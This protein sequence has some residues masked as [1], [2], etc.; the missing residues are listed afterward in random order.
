[1][2]ALLNVIESFDQQARGVRSIFNGSDGQRMRGNTRPTYLAQLAEAMKFVE[3]IW[4]GKRPIWQLQEALTTSD[5]PNLFGDIIDRM[6]LARYMELPA[7]YKQ[8]CKIGSVRDFRTVKRL[9]IDGNRGLLTQVEERSPYPQRK[10]TDG[11][12]TYAVTKY[13]G[14]IGISWETLIND[15]LDA[16][17]DIPNDLAMSARRTEEWFATGLWAGANGFNSSFVSTGNGNVVLANS[18]LGTSQNPALS[19]TA[20]QA[21]MI[22]FAS[23]TDS[24]GRPINITAAIL[25]VPPALEV[26]ARNILNATQLWLNDNGGTTSERLIAANWMQQAVSLAVNYEW[27]NV[28]SSANGNTSWALFQDPNKSRPG[29]EVG[30]LR[31]HEQPEVFRKIPNQQRVGGTGDSPID[32]D[33]NTDETEYKV[34]HCLGGTVMDPKAIMASTGAGS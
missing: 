11:D 12:Y 20:L 16:F 29:V 7:S 28:A 8:Y 18:T 27:P 4:S 33:F 21:A 19:I 17:K 6:M 31:G 32:G 14:A 1:M 5:F 10:Y 15:D 24:D 22:Q 26:T 23:R 2:S 34:R 30:F 3:Q 25:V 13:G 9:T